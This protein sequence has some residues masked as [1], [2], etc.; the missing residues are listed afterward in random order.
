MLLLVRQVNK[1]VVS[2]TAAVFLSQTIRHG[3][4]PGR[5]RPRL[6]VAVR[7]CNVLSA[8]GTTCCIEIG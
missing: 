1:V 8:L 2:D 3:P 6:F 5:P 7:K 4:D